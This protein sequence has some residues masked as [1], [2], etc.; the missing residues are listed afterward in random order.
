MFFP[1]LKDGKKRANLQLLQIWR[2]GPFGVFLILLG[3]AAYLPILFPAL[4]KLLQITQQIATMGR[5]EIDEYQMT[6]VS[7]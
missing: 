3:Q 6:L 2:H 5:V 4:L 1:R 7:R